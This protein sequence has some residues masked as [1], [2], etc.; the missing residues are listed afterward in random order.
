MRGIRKASI[1]LLIVF[2]LMLTMGSIQASDADISG[3][4][5][6]ALQEDNME[7][8]N[9]L[10]SQTDDVLKEESGS[11]EELSAVGDSVLS[12]TDLQRKLDSADS[13]TVNLTESY[14][15]KSQNDL[16]DVVITRDL[17]IVGFNNCY[18]D[19]SG[20]VRC[21]RINHDCNVVI[22]DVTFKNGYS[23]NN[24]GA[25]L[26]EDDVNLKVYN[27]VF[28][29]NKVKNAN[30]GAL[31]CHKGANTEIHNSKF[32]SNEA[33]RVSDKSWEDFKCGMGGAVIAGMG[34]NLKLYDT[35]FK[36]NNA[37]VATIVVIS[38]SEQDGYKLSKIY[39]NK[40]TFDNNT[41][42]TN[43]V[44]YS[45][46]LGKAEILNSVFKNNRATKGSGGIVLDA[47]KGSTVKGCTFEKNTGG[48]GG[49]IAIN[50]FKNHNG[51]A[52]ISDCSFSKNKADYGGAIYSKHATVK[53]SNC[54][55]NG[56]VAKDQ[57][58]AIYVN[59]GSLK[60]YSSTL[61]GNKAKQGGGLY[62]LSS[63]SNVVESTKFSKNSASDTG[64]AVYSKVDGVSSS[65]C[66]YE[67]N[68]APNT[69]NVYGSY[70]TEITTVS[71]YYGCVE[72]K[73]K[74]SSPWNMPVSHKIILKIKGTS[75]HKI[76]GYKTNSKGEVSVR[77]NKFVKRGKHTVTITLASGVSSAT[78][79][80]SVLKSPCKFKAPKLVE[81][82]GQGKLFKAK[83]VNSK[84]GKP[85]FGAKIK[86][87][88]FTGKKMKSIKCTSDE[89]GFI[90][91]KTKKLCVGKHIVKLSSMDKNLKLPKKTTWIIIK[92]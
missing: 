69:P 59:L 32:I 49:A 53:V 5:T 89:K 76:T 4:D 56:N 90:K 57:G 21:L 27:C 60:L 75:T 30:G 28:Q 68:T 40:C 25:I 8:D 22:K 64:G 43:G 14:K 72:Y 55:F 2:A 18:I 84:N 71:P 91:L 24:G 12:F 16:S 82:F 17:T 52:T 7:L 31:C 46:E 1:A 44:I 63:S 29:N 19:G 10:S 54:N 74:I 62:M 13:G 39:A 6:V 38:N 35:T 42:N 77:V 11:G 45:D 23:T 88:F 51:Q 41:S 79:K 9:D 85:I 92:K 87:T 3:N 58:G 65:K 50:Q 67:G 83:V 66:T 37:Y 61:T 20:S 70:K 47:P 81:K 80:M 15:Y 33:K 36:S 34:S 26:A 78:K 48:K 73:V 86:L